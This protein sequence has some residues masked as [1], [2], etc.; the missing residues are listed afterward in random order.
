MFMKFQLGGKRIKQTSFGTSASRGQKQ[1][2]NT[3]CKFNLALVFTVYLSHADDEDEEDQA[4]RQ[5]D[6]CT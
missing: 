1:K 2:G 5:A 3:Y 6:R 4:G